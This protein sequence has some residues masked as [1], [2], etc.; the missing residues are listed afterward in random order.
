MPQY[1]KRILSQ[2]ARKLNIIRDT[3]EKVSRLSKV[4]EYF[5]GDPNISKTL[6]LKGGTAINLTIFDLPRLS[7]DIDFD[8]AINNKRDEML[9][10]RE[11]LNE[12]IKRYMSMEGYELS[13]K[14][15]I[16]HSLDSFV[17]TYTNSAGIKDNI[18]I[19]TNYSMRCHV[20]P[21]EQRPI[22][23]QDVFSPMKVFMLNQTEIF[24]SKIVAL[25]S[26]TAARDLYDINNMLYYGLF[27]QSKEELLR[28][29]VVFYSAIGSET[30]PGLFNVENIESL[31]PHKIKTD[32]IPVIR[33]S[34]KFDLDMIKRNV[35]E[36]LSELLVLTEKE[37]QFL[38]GFRN[39]DYCP[40]LLFEGEILERVR[41]HPMALW[42]T[43]EN[44]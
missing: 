1:D 7:V 9:Q 27:D 18:K 44:K 41:N 14:S 35:K 40:E 28:K 33:K 32:L 23:A 37:K 10:E 30:V 39:N 16:Y 5:N 26:R 4:L 12:I 2:Q 22:R 20:L 24:A 6:A 8:Y 3:F 43:R 19:E 13:N 15:K 34:E 36:Y 38:E 21:L 17:F 11:I 42:K 29:C 25:L 31:T